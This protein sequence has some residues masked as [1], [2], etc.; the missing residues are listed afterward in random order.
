MKII[1]WL[2][3]YENRLD[4]YKASQFTLD[5]LEVAIGRFEGMDSPNDELPA[6]RY[7]VDNILKVLNPA[8]T[9]DVA[10]FTDFSGLLTDWIESQPVKPG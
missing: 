8:L 9:I 10:F 1:D 3:D 7:E 6:I 2:R 5:W 4:V